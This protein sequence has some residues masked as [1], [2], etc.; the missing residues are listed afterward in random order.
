M[1]LVLEQKQI[2]KLSPQMIQ[3]M[4]ILQMST[5]ELHEYVEE[6]L[7]ENP[8]LEREETYERELG[9]QLLNKLEWLAAGSR[10]SHGM[11]EEEFPESLESVAD[12]ARES[13]YDYLSSQILWNSLSLTLSR[14]VECVLSGLND[15][16]WL[17]ESQEELA[18]RGKV[19][20]AIIAQAEQLLHELD[21]AGL[22][23]RDLAQCLALQLERLGEDGLPLTI[24]HTHLEDMAK[25]HYNQIAVATGASREAVQRACRLIRSLEP[26]PGAAFACVE[27]P[28]YIAPDILVVEEE[29]ELTVHAKGEDLPRLMVS[30]YYRELLHSN[31]EVQVKEYLTQKLQ[32][33]DWV[34]KSIEQRKA[35]MLCC[36]QCIVERQ[37]EFFRFGRHYLQPMTLADV[38]SV[39]GVHESTVSRAIK[40][41]YIQC[42]WGTFPM[43][44]FFN[45][46]V[47]GDG[48]E[49]AVIRIKAFL[50]ELIESEDKRKPLSDQKL[51]DALLTKGITLARR[52]VAKY[53][54]ELGYPSAPGRKEFGTC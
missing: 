10:R 37:Q 5:L 40:N 47:G 35:T 45:R 24:V 38:A 50:R 49:I 29:G 8:V 3:S 25:D 17:D 51:C 54:D 36:A 53:R 13:L 19:S 32:Q 2:Q 18:R 23:A 20:V 26:R 48:E 14:A 28:A 12:Q 27:Q 30:S 41:K 52:T 33:A 21:P 15:N 39:V 4:E 1:E 22:G 9:S 31:E 34:L 16:G 7:L 43:G 44:F 6:Q 46:A 42:A 11:R